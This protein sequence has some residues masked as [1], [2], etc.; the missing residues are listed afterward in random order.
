MHGEEDVGCVI[1]TT[2]D[3]GLVSTGPR[4]RFFFSQILKVQE[5]KL[6]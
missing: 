6:Y 5:D 1:V 3:P 4:I 2:S